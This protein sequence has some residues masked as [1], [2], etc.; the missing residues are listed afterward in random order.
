MDDFTKGVNELLY[1]GVETAT[2]RSKTI[3]PTKA[4]I[5]KEI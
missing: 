1:S 2:E 4:I 3:P 5:R